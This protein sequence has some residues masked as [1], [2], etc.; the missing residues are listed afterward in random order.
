MA[1]SQARA[2]IVRSAVH[3]QAIALSMPTMRAIEL[4]RLN[5]ARKDLPPN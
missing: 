4:K 5:V 3:R 1:L 2:A